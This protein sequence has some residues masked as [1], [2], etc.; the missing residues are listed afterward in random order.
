[1]FTPEEIQR[2]QDDAIASQD[3]ESATPEVVAATPEVVPTK[4]RKEREKMTSKWWAFF[5]KGIVKNGWYDAKCI[6]CGHVFQMGHNRGTSSLSNHIKKS[7]KK[8]PMD[9]RYQPDALQKML[10]LG[11]E[12]GK[13]F[14]FGMHFITCMT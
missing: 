5:E 9:K 7:C 10:K 11:S 1:M 3:P 8:V 4:K 14:Q 6:Y 2:I 13:S 12:K